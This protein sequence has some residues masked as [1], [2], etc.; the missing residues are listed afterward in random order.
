MRI[1]LAA[2][3][4]FLS[5][6]PLL[7]G[8]AGFAFLQV[9]AGARAVAMGGAFTAVPGDPMG[10]Y[11]NPATLAGLQGQ[12]FTS[13]YTG[14]LMDMQAGFAGWANPSGG[15]IV[16]VSVNYFYGGSFTRTTMTE[17]TGTGEE[18][19]TNSVALGGTYVH[20]FGPDLSAGTTAKF[21][22]SSIDTYNGTAFLVDLGAWYRPSDI[23][24]G[25][26]VRN[27]G[28]QTKAFYRENDPMPTEIAAGASACFLGDRLLV[29]L[30]GSYP[31]QG[32]FNAAVGLEYK[33]MEMLAVRAGGNLRD[34]DAADNA[35]GGFLDALAFGAGTGWNRF[36]LDYAF[37]PLADLGNIHRFSVGIAL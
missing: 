1:T 36:T 15:D 14:Y 29:A 17:P 24:L 8:T 4:L 11:W 5:A 34:L 18:F 13:T 22:Y 30:D 33:P 6:A 10:L 35:G 20:S 28:I 12:M 9:P 31:F 2:G 25:L 21:V 7:A 26:V 23:S 37:K 32:D 3:L 16:G 19:S 27:A